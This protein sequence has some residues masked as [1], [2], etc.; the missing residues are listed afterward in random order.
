[1]K[2]ID[3]MAATPLDIIIGNPQVVQFAPNQTVLQPIPG[4]WALDHMAMRL[5]GTLTLSGYTTPPTKFLESEENLIASYQLQATGSGSQAS[6]GQLCAVDAAYLRFKTRMMEGT[7]VT[8]TEVGTANGAYQFETNFRR[9]YRDPRS[10]KATLTRLFMAQ[11]QSLVASFQFR[12]QNAMVYG[13]I[14]GAAVL[15]NVQV[16]TQ[17]RAYLGMTPNNPQPYVREQQRLFN[18]NQSQDGFVCDKVPLNT[19]LR[20]QYFKGMLGPTNY[21]DPSDSVFG[22]A[23]KAEG[24]HVTLTLNQLTNRLDQVYQSIK[25][26]DKLL[27]GVES[28]PAGYAIFEPARNRRLSASIPMNGVVTATNNIDVNYTPGSLN[29]IQ[30]TDETINNVS[31]D[32]YTA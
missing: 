13:G 23:T 19:V 26:D 27:F 5:T 20:R 4:A 22:S 31:K 14:G 15:S 21:G 8:R 1:L 16:V 25:N 7:D 30:I 12:D 9:Y 3:P 29:T 11:L 28:I 10:D 2:G 6:T 32:Q 24:P 18:V 17:V